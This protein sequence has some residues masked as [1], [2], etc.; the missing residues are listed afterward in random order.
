MLLGVLCLRP[1]PA[2]SPVAAS[3]GTRALKLKLPSEVVRGSPIEAIIRGAA[4]S[5]HVRETPEQ[6]IE[7][8]KRDARGR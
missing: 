2:H 8:A 7:A 6:C 1:S 5:G 4:P 3:G